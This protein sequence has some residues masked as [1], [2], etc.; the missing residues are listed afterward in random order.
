MWT[1]FASDDVLP[2]YNTKMQ[3]GDE[4]ISF[5]LYLSLFVDVMGFKHID[6]KVLC[7]VKGEVKRKK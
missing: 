2:L 3:N 4:N 1:I 5:L 6:Y 7:V